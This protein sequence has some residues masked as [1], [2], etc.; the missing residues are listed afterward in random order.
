[1]ILDLLG[2]LVGVFF[3]MCSQLPS[4]DAEMKFGHF[5]LVKTS[6]CRNI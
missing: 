5:L 1:M 3:K 2:W 4:K 6:H